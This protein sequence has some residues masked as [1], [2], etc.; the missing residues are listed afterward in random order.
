MDLNYSQA[1]WR[2]STHTAQGSSCV[3]IA[4]VGKQH[5]VRDT[6]DRQGPVLAFTPTEW[7]TFLN[8]IKS[9][10][11]TYRARHPHFRS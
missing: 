3:E 8:T 4:T 1:A 10:G 7:T 9:T 6:K 2:T 5:L 11:S